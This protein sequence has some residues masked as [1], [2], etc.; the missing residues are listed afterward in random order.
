MPS[1]K[2]DLGRY[3][4]VRPRLDGTARVLFEVPKRLRPSDWSAA[5]PLPVNG[6]RRGDLTDAEEVARIQADAKRLLDRLRAARMGRE[7]PAPARSMPELIRSWQSTQRFK[8]KKP[9]TQKGYIY[10][11]GLIKAWSAANGH[12]PVD[13]IKLEAIEAFLAH[14]DDR[15]TT[16]RHLKIVMSMLLDRAIQLEWRTT[17][18]LDTVKMGAPKSKVTIWEADDVAFYIKACK[19]QG[20]PS[21]AAMI[22]TLWEIGQRV[23]DARLF[24]SG[25]EYVDG[26][27]RFWQSKTDSWVTV[28]VS[29]RTRDLIAEVADPDS[30]YLFTDKAT[31]KPWDEA[32]LG[33]VFADI[34]SEAK[35]RH[36]VLRALR[37]SC[38]VQ[39]ARAGSD[40]PEIASVTGHAP[41]TAAQILAKYL[42]RDNA[43]AAKAQ[44][45]RGI[46]APKA[47]RTVRLA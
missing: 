21:I 46:A 45:R 27:F 26:A 30:L 9:K 4:T 34:R 20:Q 33:H 42:P 47:G 22:S 43:L 10:H 25:A 16:R 37:H 12:K 14:Y 32:R 8:D 17:N 2:L 44:K 36:L 6:E 1:I 29:K 38:V 13:R 19:D 31:G 7:A 24:R 18:P 15:P 28:R 40:V 35:G 23:T 3:V 11:A 5:I 39:M 41:G